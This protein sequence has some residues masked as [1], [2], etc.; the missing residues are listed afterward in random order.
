M[1][2]WISAMIL[3]AL[4]PA[5]LV[6]S[7]TA[8]SPEYEIRVQ[9]VLKHD[10]GKTLWYHPRAAAIP[11][12]GKEG[13]PAVVMTLQQHLHTSDHYSGM[14]ILRSDDWGRNWSGPIL[15]PELDWRPQADGATLAVC[16]V[17]PGWHEKSKRYLAIGAQVRYSPKGEQLDDTYRAN[18]TAYAVFDPKS[19]KWSGWK[20]IELPKDK[21]FDTARSACAQW[22]VKPDGHLL[23]PFYYGPTNDFPAQVTVVEASFDGSEL[24][25]IRH[26]SELALNVVR[27]LVEPSIAYHR[28]QYYLTIRNDLRAY[29]T[30]SNDGLTW[31]PI[32]PWTFDDG[33]DLGSYNTQAHWLAHSEGLFLLYTRRGANNDHVIRNGAPL[34]MAQVDPEKLHVVR[35][36]ER[37][38]LPERGG[39]YRNFGA[40]AMSDRESWVTVGE[41]VWDDDARRR[42]AD[43][44]LFVARIIWAKRNRDWRRS[45]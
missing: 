23:L 17:T 28:G 21:K 35:S 27:G 13:K 1:N 20:I 38:I 15:Q 8:K 16:D 39:E 14:S 6:A 44:S 3:P 36:T 33:K 12:Y 40:R 24:K 5:A 18:Q 4:L 37:V 43:G 45:P 41:G 30:R 10:D 2:R 26:G 7:E 29:V 22:L 32:R 31:E 42:G 25:Y 11:G 9:A 34:F 19:K